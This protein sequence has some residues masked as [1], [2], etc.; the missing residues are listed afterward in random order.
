MIPEPLVAFF[1]T[2]V[3]VQGVFFGFV[4]L[5]RRYR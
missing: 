5:S 1:A 2:I 4:G 3:E